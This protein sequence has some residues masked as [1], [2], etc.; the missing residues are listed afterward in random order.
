MQNAKSADPTGSHSGSKS[1]SGGKWQNESTKYGEG[2]MSEALIKSI[3]Q[4]ETLAEKVCAGMVKETRRAYKRE[5]KA[6]LQWLFQTG[7]TVSFESVEA[8]KEAMIQDQRGESGINQALT[9]IRKMIRKMPKYGLL[10]KEQSDIICSVESVKIRGK[11]THNW[12][13]IQEA[14][15]LLAAPKESKRANSLLAYRDRAIL[16]LLVG[17]GLRRAEVQSITIEHIQQREGRW[18][19]VD[20]V[21][22]RN[23]ARTVPM[24]NWCKALIDEWLRVSGIKEGQI[25]R[26]CSWKNQI[27][28]GLQFGRFHIGDLLSTTSIY[29]AVG[30]YAL[31]CL[32]RNI[33]PHDLRRSF[34]KLARSGGAELEQI[35]NSLGHDSL[36]TTQAYLGTE[37][38]YQ[39][40]PSDRLG[41][42]VDV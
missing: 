1:E 37:I 8:Y 40:A 11:K 42:K 25:I 39:N 35:M 18:V 9:A 21:G 23:K 15:K 24:A 30:R 7:Q 32:G 4:I 6:F 17:C 10:T 41:L 13:T 19:I 36:S 27:D 26:Q 3:N 38:D 14:E 29:H 22:K 12:L 31:A 5:I 34:A 28:D 16:A 20:I 2:N 33:A